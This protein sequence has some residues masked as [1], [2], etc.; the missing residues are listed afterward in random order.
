MENARKG[1]EACYR[2][3]P[4]KKKRTPDDLGVRPTC[5]GII[6]GVMRGPDYRWRVIPR[7]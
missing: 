6:W 2:R 1:A 3:H 4:A 5:L 7:G